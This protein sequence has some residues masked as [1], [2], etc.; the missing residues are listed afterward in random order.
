[1][2]PSESRAAR[3]AVAWAR[4]ERAQARARRCEETAEQ[5]ERLAAETGLDAHLDLAR[6]HRRAAACHLSSAAIQEAYA[7]RMTRWAEGDGVRPLFMSGVAEACGTPS[8]ALTLVGADRSQLAFAA[9]DRPAHRA[10]DLEYTLGEGPAVDAAAERRGLYLARAEFEA[11]WPGYG[12]A[13]TSL[14]IAR[15]AA[16]PLLAGDEPGPCLGALAV[17]DPEPG[18]VESGAFARVA[19]A[20]VRTVLVGLDAEPEL[21][22]GV[23]HR[24]VVHQAAGVLSVQLECTVADALARIKARAFAEG[25]TSDALALRVVSGELRIGR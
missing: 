13:L 12:P 25:T 24:D 1:M 11:R 23:D 9:S 19:A 14:G 10:Q 3:A 8:A 18:V 15:V 17:F 6:L 2:E 5:H 16:T 4:A 22:G 7:R 20:L 21:Y